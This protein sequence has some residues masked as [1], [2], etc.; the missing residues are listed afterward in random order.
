M[1]EEKKVGDDYEPK[2][3]YVAV[4]NG[5]WDKGKIVLEKSPVFVALIDPLFSTEHTTVFSGGTDGVHEYV[6]AESGRDSILCQVKF[7]D[8]P[9]KKVGVNGVH[10]EDLLLMVLNRLRHFQKGDFAC[11]E[12]AIAITKIE[13][14]VMWL[15]NRTLGRQAR[16]VEG[17]Y[18]V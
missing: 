14:A 13:E 7:Q 5:D 12:N 3:G 16:G 2:G 15:R 10:N 4:D 9:I 8:G 17:T 18:E 11:R 6:V 1:S